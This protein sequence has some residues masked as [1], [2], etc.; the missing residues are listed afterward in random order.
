[1]RSYTRV[2]PHKAV[3]KTWKK[4][5]ANARA[6]LR[7]VLDDAALCVS[8]L[9]CETGNADD[10]TLSRELLAGLDRKHRDQ[11]AGVL[12]E[13]FAE[14]VAVLSYGRDPANAPPQSR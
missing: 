14:C 6:G 4:L 11:V 13:V 8:A 9:C 10:P 3:D 5:S 12:Q 7:G 2:V 1:M